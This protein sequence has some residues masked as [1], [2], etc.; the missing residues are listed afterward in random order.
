[1]LQHLRPKKQLVKQIEESNTKYHLAKAR[2]DLQPHVENI[3]DQKILTKN[4][5][6]LVEQEPPDKEKRL[7]ALN[8]RT[9]K[10]EEDNKRKYQLQFSIKQA[11]LKREAK[12]AKRNSFLNTCTKTTDPYGRP[13]KAVVKNKHPPA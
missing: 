13:Y 4:K 11:E 8:K 9:N 3:Q 6:Q 10:S 5:Q 1:M 12:K 2:E 7:Q